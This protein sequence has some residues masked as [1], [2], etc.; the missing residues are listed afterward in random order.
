MESA[1][2]HFAANHPVG[3]GHFPGNP[4]IPGALLLDEI[5]RALGAGIDEPVVIKSAKF[6]RPLRPGEGVL[7]QFQS[8]SGGLKK[9]ECHLAGENVLVAS[10][11]VGIGEDAA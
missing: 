4:I 11:T 1:K 10:G 6:F 9:F 7:V 2:I 8:L 5:I 3:P